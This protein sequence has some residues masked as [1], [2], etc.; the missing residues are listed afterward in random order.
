MPCENITTGN[1]CLSPSPLGTKSGFWTDALICSR[2]HINE[3]II[4]APPLTPLQSE[5]SSTWQ[6]KENMSRKMEMSIKAALKRKLYRS[7]IQSMIQFGTRS[8][9]WKDTL[10]GW[11]TQMHC[12]IY[13]LTS[14]LPWA[15][16][17]DG[18]QTKLAFKHMIPWME[19]EKIDRCWKLQMNSAMLQ[20]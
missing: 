18:Y 16:S 9:K 7:W 11:F 10:S 8:A 12:M 13:N 14:T 6:K 20:L 15:S 1:R 19:S 4:T 2:N 3:Y 17:V 5:Q